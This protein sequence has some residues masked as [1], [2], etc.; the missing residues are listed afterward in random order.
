MLRQ[1]QSNII[2]DRSLIN[3]IFSAGY[4]IGNLSSLISG[5]STPLQ[6]RPSKISAAAASTAGKV[7]AQTLSQ[8]IGSLPSGEGTSDGDKKRSIIDMS[9]II[10]R[11]NT[12]QVIF[13]F[14]GK[15]SWPPKKIF[16]TG[17]DSSHLLPRKC[18]MIYK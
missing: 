7:N 11:N 4:P 1:P 10:T 3:L 12:Q 14:V 16:D 15:K 6:S 13:Y 5:T 2:V 18:E 17:L 8:I 9:T